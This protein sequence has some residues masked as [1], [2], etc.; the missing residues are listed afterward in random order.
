MEISGSGER[1][2]EESPR[3][4]SLM[5]HFPNEE[6]EKVEHQ[7]NHPMLSFL[8]FEAKKYFEENIPI[9]MLSEFPGSY[10]FPLGTVAYMVLIGVFAYFM[11]SSYQDAISQAYISLEKKGRG[12]CSD[13]PIKVS[14]NFLAD[15]TGSWIDTP[16]FDYYDAA[17]SFD[18]ASLHVNSVREYTQMILTFKESLKMVGNFGPSSNLAVNLIIWMTF[19][20]FYSVDYPEMMNF[21]SIGYGQLQSVQMT[22]TPSVVFEAQ[23]YRAVISDPAGLC[24]ISSQVSFDQANA[25]LS[26]TYDAIAYDANDNCGRILPNSSYGVG[27]LPWS[28]ETYSFTLDVNSFSIAMAINLNFLGIETL[29]LANG[30]VISLN[31]QGVQ[32]SLGNYFDSRFPL[33]QSLF[34]LRN[35]S[36]IPVTG[37]GIRQLCIIQANSLAA[38]PVFNH[39]GASDDVPEAC[40]CSKPVGR[41]AV[42]NQVRLVSSLV[43]YN[44]DTSSGNQMALIQQQVASIFAV[45][46]KYNGNYRLFNAAAFNATSSS[47]LSGS[48]VGTLPP[49]YRANAFKFCELNSG[50]SCSLVSWFSF[51]PNFPIVSENKFTLLNGSCM[52]TLRINDSAWDFMASHPPVALIQDYFECYNSKEQAILNAAGIATG[53]ASL[54]MLA[55]FIALVPVIYIFLA[56]LHRVPEKGEYSDKQK[57]NALDT[58]ATVLL[59]VRDDKLLNRHVV[60]EKLFDELL[61]VMNEGDKNAEEVVEIIRGEVDDERGIS[62]G[63]GSGGSMK[64]GRM[65][66]TYMTIDRTQSSISKMDRKASFGYSHIPKMSKR[67]SRL[68]RMKSTGRLASSSSVFDTAFD[69]SQSKAKSMRPF[70]MGDAHNYS[71]IKIGDSGGGGGDGADI[72]RVMNV[73]NS[74]EPNFD[75]QAKPKLSIDDLVNKMTLLLS[76]AMLKHSPGPVKSKALT[77]LS[78]PSADNVLG[79]EVT[80]ADQGVSREYLEAFR[81]SLELS[82]YKFEDLYSREDRVIFA[83]LANALCLHTSLELSVELSQVPSSALADS[84]AYRVGNRVLTYTALIG[85]SLGVPNGAR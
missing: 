41:S 62:V 40:D 13:V 22:G 17:F 25:R 14:G 80:T 10:R 51:S 54:F 5:L 39:V 4:A 46:A 33:M 76:A 35:T 21:E 83:Q 6:E 15:T 82:K 81:Y 32:Y 11:Y 2:V 1:V 8:G 73:P 3:R 52:D 49:G 19:I 56:I 63:S 59:R 42:C 79:N 37:L 48:N 12:L 85:Y 24:N 61:E 53:N 64:L 55:L 78:A 34:C 47:V 27:M 18:F 23:F 26:L 50:Q 20:R 68:A 57:G 60:V 16:D 74:Y 58:F 7:K 77:A 44:V 36:A 72:M 9:P 38:L 75:R 66:S 69:L 67:D 30:A 28:M 45:L 84:V 71:M 65:K 31:I 70:T 29:Q 43:V